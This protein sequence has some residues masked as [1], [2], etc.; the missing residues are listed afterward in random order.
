MS[1]F[2]NAILYWKNNSCVGLALVPAPFNDKELVLEV[3]EKTYAR[4]P[5]YNTLIVVNNFHTR[6]FLIEYL[7]SKN[8]DFE[9]IIEKGYI[10]IFT[11]D[12]AIKARNALGNVKLL[13]LY[14]IS[15]M[16]IDL[17]DV[18]KFIPYRLCILRKR[19]DK[20]EDMS[21]IYNLTPLLDI[22]KQ[23]EVDELRCSTPVEEMQIGVTLTN[24]EDTKL[25]EYYN[26]FILGSVN[27][28]GSFDV[29]NKCNTGD[30]LSNTSAMQ[31]CY[32]IAVE[33]GWNENLDMNV[34]FNIKIDEMYNPANLKERAKQTYE[35]VRKRQDL[36]S[37]NKSKLSYI[38]DIIKDNIGKKILIINKKGSFANDVVDY[39]NAEFGDV[40]AGYHDN[41]LTANM[42]DINGN[43]IFYRTGSKAGQPK[44]MGAKAQKSNN[45]RRFNN[46]DI[47]ILVTN[48]SPDK[49]L[50][51]TVDVIIITSP[52]CE[53]IKTYFY[54]L[55]NV[56]Y[57][58]KVLLYS[59]Y[60]KNTQEE[61][62]LLHK[63][64]T[65]NHIIVKKCENIL[66][67][68]ENN[69]FIVVD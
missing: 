31:L 15:D 44:T 29:M 3:L 11:N 37:S 34:P 12:F 13:I 4:S 26:N 45:E 50:N 68:E 35:F 17:Y 59:L 54:R 57:N 10:K 51:I 24:Q 42:V 46:G 32:Q 38:N 8:A 22:F 48:N 21:R 25:L 61:K 56:R 9:S 58:D 63:E 67:D 27:I 36:L 49:K 53:S 55:S 43:P 62:M 5:T 40:S 19:L 6:L 41:L 66:T 60:I 47:S 39:I 64:L 2:D 65:N 23:V 69:A 28:F 52:L 16:P 30:Y 1:N 18:C 33:N 7:K 14:S 20:D